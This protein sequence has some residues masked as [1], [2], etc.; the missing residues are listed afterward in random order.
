MYPL[1][2]I[3]LKYSYIH[4]NFLLEIINFIVCFHCRVDFLLFIILLILIRN[5]FVKLSLTIKSIVWVVCCHLIHLLILYLL[6][7]IINI[8]FIIILEYFSFS[9][10]CCLILLFFLNILLIFISELYHQ[11]F[12][13]Q[14]KFDY[15]FLY[16]QVEANFVKLEC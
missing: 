13:K 6:A 11:I 2:K 3:Y 9:L 8:I 16:Y 14:V 15:F 1:T 12:D 7:F 4:K 5:H 10:I